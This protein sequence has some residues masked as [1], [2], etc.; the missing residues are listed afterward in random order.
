MQIK[1]IAD[2]IHVFSF[3]LTNLNK[4]PDEDTIYRCTEFFHKLDNE[5]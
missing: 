1:R 2:N 4:E 3:L 5:K